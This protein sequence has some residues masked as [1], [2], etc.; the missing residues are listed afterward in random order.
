MPDAV[1]CHILSFLFTT[2]AVKTSVLS[3]RWKNVWAS[4]PV[5]DLDEEEYDADMNQPLYN[6]EDCFAQ[7]VNRVLMFRCSGDIHRFRLATNGMDDV[8][9]I[10][11]WISTAIRRNVVEFDLTVQRSTVPPFEIPKSLFMCS[12]LVRFKLWL[13]RGIRVMIPTSSNCFPSLK[14]LHVTVHF[15]DSDSME[16]LFSRL[17]VL[18]ELIIDGNFVESTT[19][20]L[21]ISAPKLKRLQTELRV[22]KHDMHFANFVNY[23][24]QILVNVDAPNLEE[25]DICFDPLVSFSLKNAK[26]LRKAKIDFFYVEELKKHDYFLGLADRI[27]QIFAGIYDAKYLTVKAPLL[28]ALDIGHQYLL[29]TFNNLNYLELQLH[30]CRCLQSLATVL[31]ISPHLEQLKIL[32]NR[33]HM[34]ANENNYS[35][36]VDEDEVEPEWDAPETVPV[37]LI[38]HLKTICLWDFKGCPDDMEVAKYLVQHGKALNRVTIHTPFCEN[39]EMK[40]QSA[41]A[42]WSNVSKF[43]RGS[44]TCEIEFQ[45]II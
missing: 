32:L 22:F 3:H 9:L 41:T 43:P 27:H 44:K 20:N 34:Y 40:S 10:Y 18:E 17:P 37:C 5:L 2:E 8:S 4:V 33:K 11:A 13:H 7:F 16:K 45:T 1:L 39:K 29:P 36:D 35:D 14:F 28:A 21:D 6:P 26:C 30:T 15:P 12:T 24:C 25:L 23:V 42:L 31:K 19:S 38:S